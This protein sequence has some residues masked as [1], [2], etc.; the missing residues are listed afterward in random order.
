VTVMNVGGSTASDISLL[1]PYS[2]SYFDIENAEQD[3]D[4][5]APGETVVITFD[6]SSGKEISDG[7]TYS[8]SI[9]F[10]YTNIMGRTTTFSD[11]E[12]NS[13][14]IRIKDRV[15]PSEQTQVIKNDGQIVSEG[16]GNIILGI[17]IIVA[18]IL[19]VRL[20]QG[21]PKLE[22]KNIQ[23]APK[24]EKRSKD[25]NMGKKKIVVEDDDEEEED[26]EED[27]EEEDDHDW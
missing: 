26:E 25:L 14:S 22:I 4:D 16:A 8:F 12:S 13:F 2:A 19:F 6:I 15:I 18:V 7:T 11:A 20:T 21:R 27:E 1:L 9:R 10:A 3:M 23:E 17:L 24:E 5:L